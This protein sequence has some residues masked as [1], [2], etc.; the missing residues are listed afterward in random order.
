MYVKYEM[1]LANN[2][3]LFSSIS[4][5]VAHIPDLETAIE[6]AIQKKID[7]EKEQKQFDMQTTLATHYLQDF[8]CERFKVLL[9]VQELVF[10]IGQ[11]AKKFEYENDEK[12]VIRDAIDTYR[13]TVSKIFTDVEV[14][15][16]PV[17]DKNEETEEE[18]KEREEKERKASDEA[19][20][21]SRIAM[22]KPSWE[23]DW[24]ESEGRSLEVHFA[25]IS[26]VFFVSSIHVKSVFLL[27]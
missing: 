9:D 8:A 21:M 16:P 5:R 10:K 17:G 12:K 4:V 14:L 18:R 3:I 27:Y 11:E 6:V 26:Y 13:M 25:L 7:L 1:E 23:M 24:S 2:Y 19:I 20:Y 22:K 15:A